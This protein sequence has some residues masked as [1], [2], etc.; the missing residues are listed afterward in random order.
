VLTVVLKAMGYCML[1]V[2]GLVYVRE[3]CVREQ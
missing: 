1:R 3:H 2:S